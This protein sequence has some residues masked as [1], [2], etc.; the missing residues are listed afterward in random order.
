MKD[1]LTTTDKFPVHNVTHKPRH[2]QGDWGET[3]TPDGSSSSEETG[4]F[5]SQMV[6]LERAIKYYKDNQTSKTASLYQFTTEILELVLKVGI[7]NI[8]NLTKK[9]EE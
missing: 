3:N 7:D 5:D 8:K 6:T 4:S 1:T 9:G 2:M